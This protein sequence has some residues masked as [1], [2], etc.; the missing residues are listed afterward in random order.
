MSTKK[1]IGYSEFTDRVYLGRQNRSKGIWIGDKEDI[2]SD[3]LAVCS[4]YFKNGVR[5]VNVS[6]G[7]KE[8]FIG[9][10]KDDKQIK[11]LIKYLE[12]LVEND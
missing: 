1:A 4:V 3:F 6:N 10:N 12:K 11:S 9:I 5:E 8:L 2:T 7:K